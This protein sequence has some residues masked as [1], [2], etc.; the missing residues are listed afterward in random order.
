MTSLTPRSPRRVVEQEELRPEHLR[1]RCAHLHADDLAPAVGVH[2]NSYYYSNGHDPPRLPHLDISCINPQVRPAAFYGTCKEGMDTIV[3]LR[4]QTRDLA[5]GDPRHPH[6]LHKVVNG[7]CR[8]AVYVGF[9]DDGHQRLLGSTP[10][11]QEAGEVAALPQLRNGQ[12][13]RAGP[14]LPATLAIAIALVHSGNGAFAVPRASQPLHVQLHH[15][16][17]NEADHLLEEI[18]IRPLLNESFQGHPV[19]RHGPSLRLRLRLRNP[20][21]P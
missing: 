16:V 15:P 21:Q 6:R 12:L 13:H 19:D 2:R 18:I 11:L 14:R 5:L 9:L 10:R 8:N 1:L 7:A 4:T 3:N 17:G 20:S